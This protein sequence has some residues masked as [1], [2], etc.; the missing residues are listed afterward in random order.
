MYSQYIW[1]FVYRSFKGTAAKAKSRGHRKAGKWSWK[2]K[3]IQRNLTNIISQCQEKNAICPNLFVCTSAAGTA[4]AGISDLMHAGQF[5]TMRTYTAHL[6]ILKHTFVNTEP[7]YQSNLLLESAGCWGWDANGWIC[8]LC[9]LPHRCS[10]SRVQCG[11]SSSVLL[12]TPDLVEHIL[13]GQRNHRS[14]SDQVQTQSSQ[15]HRLA[16]KQTH[17]HD[18]QSLVSWIDLNRAW[19]LCFLIYSIHNN[20]LFNTIFMYYD[21]C[22]VLER[23]NTWSYHGTVHIQK[24]HGITMA[25]FCSCIVASVKS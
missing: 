5:S 21:I 13:W 24:I 4:G 15:E 14:N 11:G 23:E 25:L 22:R 8:V 20:I 12:H 1:P 16:T 3:L 9:V 10:S 18:F 17:T 19:K 7:F 6:T 2:T